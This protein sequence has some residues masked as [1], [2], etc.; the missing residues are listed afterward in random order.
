MQRHLRL[1]YIYA[2]WSKPDNIHKETLKQKWKAYE[3][4]I[5]T[6]EGFAVMEVDSM[7]IFFFFFGRNCLDAEPGAV[8][9]AERDCT[10]WGLGF[11]FVLGFHFFFLSI[12]GGGGQ[13]FRYVHFLTRSASTYW[14]NQFYYKF[15]SV[16][17]KTY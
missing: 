6:D 15:P 12:W 2:S 14:S 9:M 4:G 5:K 7:M 8:F 10:N 17:Q 13:G 16:I 1:G 11:G 3:D